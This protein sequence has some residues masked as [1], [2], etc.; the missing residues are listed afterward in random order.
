MI[1]NVISYTNYKGRFRSS[2][3]LIENAFWYVLSSYIS[4]IN[5]MVLYK[6]KQLDVNYFGISIAP[7]GSGKSFVYDTVKSLFD[8][9]R[10]KQALKASYINAN[11]DIDNSIVIEGIESKLE[12]Y[13]PEF[14][15]SIEG[16]KEG[17]YLRALALSKCFSGSLNIISEEIMDVIKDSLLNQMKELYD[18]K[19]LGK[20]IKGNINEN[21]YGIRANMFIFGSSVGIKRDPKTYEHFINSINS[22]IYRRSFIYYEEPRDIEMSSQLDPIEIDI[23]HI[24]S[25]ISENKDAITKGF[26][27]ILEPTEEAYEYLELINHELLDFANKYKDDER[28]SSEIGSFDKILKL[29][30]LKAISSNKKAIDYDSIDYAYSFYKRLRETNKELFNVDPQHKRIYKIIK[31]NKKVT[32]SEILEK[33]VFNRVTFNEDIRLVEEICYRKNERLVVVGSKIKFYSIEPMETNNLSKIIISTPKNDRKERTVNYNSFELPMFGEGYSLENL[34]K[35]ETISNFCLVHFLNGQRK[36]ENIINK[37][38]CIGID[39]DVGS[40]D[41]ILNVLNEP[42]ICYLIYT[43]R[44]HRKEKNGFISDRFRILIPLRT[45][46]EI[47][48]E[49][50]EILLDNIANALNINIYDKSAKDMGRL[51]FTNPEAQIFKNAQGILFNPVPFLPDTE[52]EEKIRKISFIND[53]DEI[54]KRIDGMIKWTIASTTYK[55]N[56]NNNLMR[57]GLFAIDLLNSVELAKQLVLE[58]NQLLDNPLEEK[59]IEKTI[60]KTLERRK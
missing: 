6:N 25:F 2:N 35:A 26:P 38:N 48:P 41:N 10:W 46:V 21:I 9:N 29:G 22:G 60:F 17:L 33:D 13:L 39:V 3:E 7:S 23:S 32:K 12:L 50:Y 57:L 44:N 27:T 5:P 51:W 56:R 8:L 58:T 34:V 47:E 49:R 54:G 24:Y 31:A 30:Y 42:N 52:K 53:K 36:K 20:V 15:N 19:F 11:K 28:F 43:T 18:G 59:E 16:T 14:E 1:N 4:I 45:V 55:G 37:V 40:I